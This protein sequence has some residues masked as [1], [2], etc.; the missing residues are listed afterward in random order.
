MSELSLAASALSSIL[1]IP[2]KTYDECVANGYSVSPEQILDIN[3]IHRNSLIR[4]EDEVNEV[5]D[6]STFTYSNDSNFCQKPF[7]RQSGNVCEFT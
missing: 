5:N 7:W 2:V 4:V 1:N 3:F 6:I